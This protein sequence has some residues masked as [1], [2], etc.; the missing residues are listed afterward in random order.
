[1]MSLIRRPTPKGS[2]EMARLIAEMCAASTTNGS[3]R[4]RQQFH[5][6]RKGEASSKCNGVFS[7]IWKWNRDICISMMQAPRSYHVSPFALHFDA[8]GTQPSRGSSD[9]L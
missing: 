6:T 7:L 9:T 2:V 1:M 5:M 3:F 4:L 8:R